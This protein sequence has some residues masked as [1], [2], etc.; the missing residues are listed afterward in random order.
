MDTGRDGRLS[1]CVSHVSARRTLTLGRVSEILHGI[2][3]C[4]LYILY[5]FLP[6]CPTISI[7]QKNLRFTIIHTVHV[8]Y[9]RTLPRRLAD[10]VTVLSL[11]ITFILFLMRS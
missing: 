9:Q 6:T 10:T 7:Y 5:P 8:R 2:Y 1:T 4:Y 11:I 3:T